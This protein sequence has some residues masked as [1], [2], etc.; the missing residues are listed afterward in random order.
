MSIRYKILLPFLACLILAGGLA[1]ATGLSSLAA[2]RQL[3]SLAERTIDANEA[4]RIARDRF[5]KGEQLIARVVA[6]TDLIDPRA[7]ATE[8]RSINEALDVQ[9]ERLRG[10]AISD[11]M[12]ELSVEAKA[13]ALRW[14]ADAEV[15][16]GIRAADAV[17]TAELMGRHSLDLRSVLEESVALAGREARARFAETESTGRWGLGAILGLGLVLAAAGAFAA[18]RITEHLSRPLL[19]LVGNASRLAGGDEAVQVAG[20]DRRDEIGA[21]AAAVQVFKDN[22]VRTRQLEEHTVLAR[23]GAE[24]QRRAGMRDLADAF[25]RSVGG[26]IGTV[27]AAA[28]QLQATAQSMTAT[29]LH[30]VDRS[31]EVATTADEAAVTIST[32]AAAAEQLGSSVHEIGRQVDSSAS[33][34]RLAVDEAA[35]TGALVRD[36]T[37]AATRIGDV[38]GLISTVADQTNLLALNATIEAARA[39]EAGRGFAVV[40][41][42]VKELAG[43]TARATGEIATQIGRIQ[44]STG[45]AVSVI[46]RIESRIQEIS[47]VAIAIAASVDEQAAA[48]QEIVRHI[49]QAAAGASR[50]NASITDV[51][52]AAGQTGTAASGVLV[53]ASDL[54]RQS[55][56]LT[57]EIARFLTTVRAA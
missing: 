23:A 46:G 6:M 53:S 24:A 11:R 49:G 18:W 2:I 34:S 25:E 45:Q 37:D 36:L 16:L 51:A 47:G 13:R 26:I 9:L 32:V 30:T 1:V 27:A 15:L 48:T 19:V 7:V 42:E 41:A 40:A 10:A 21:M 20:L 3:A 28:S 39:G 44:A 17:P 50:V 29:A 5:A 12:G 43:Q 52:G 22:L 14:T 33:L 56:D 55:G 54:S 38:I 8:F 57:R 35:Q 4:S 31:T